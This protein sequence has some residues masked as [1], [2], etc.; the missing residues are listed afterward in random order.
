M[1]LTSIVSLLFPKRIK[2]RKQMFL[3][4]QLVFV[5]V[6]GIISTGCGNVST[7]DPSST[8]KAALVKI[9]EATIHQAE[10]TITDTLIKSYIRVLAAD[11]LLGR[12]PFTLGEDRT[13]HYLTKQFKEIGWDPGNKGSYLQAVPMVQINSTPVKELN[14]LTK[15]TSFT[16]AYKKDYVASSEREQESIELKNCPIVFAGFGIVAPEYGWNDYKNLDVKGKVVL[17][18]VNDPGFEGKDPRFFKGDTMTYY[19]RWTYKY[20]EAARQGAAGVLIIHQT[21]PASYGWS[22]VNNSFTGDKL[23]LQA[24]DKHASRCKM[25]GW[26]S[27]EA[28]NHLFKSSGLSINVA[29]ATVNARKREFRAIPL[30]LNLTLNLH[31]KLKYSTSYNL[32]AM[33]KGADQKAQNIIYTAHWDHL[34]IGPSINGDSIY[35]GAI[36]NGSGVAALLSIGKAFQALKTKLPRSVILLFVTAEEQGLLG[37]EFYA[38]HPIFPLNQTIANINL[39][40]LG[41]YGTTKD[42]S[43]V[44]LGQ[45]ELDDYVQKEA[46]SEGRHVVG[47]PNPG[48]GSYF[49]SDH[50][51]FAKVGI[52]ALDLG[53]GTESIAKGAAW[54]KKMQED[55][56]DHHYHQPSDEYSP[57]MDASGMTQNARLFF[58][59]GYQ[60]SVTNMIPNWKSGSEFKE[61]REKSKP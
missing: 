26:I 15:S 33:M 54:G 49:R 53:E 36:D 52:P 14:I 18:L 44:G 39:D 2:A 34:G 58:K 6:G 47:D 19:G 32:I 37:S 5:V 41:M 9:S 28:S 57:S 46:I 16:L 8:S 3:S 24:Y 40:A 7:D 10:N 43:L 45:S 27:E 21:K 11:S 4:F 29:E 31:N 25:E 50:F 51:N 55:Y 12:K 30:G 23:L 13:L 1:M 60:L 48:A 20:E 56:N 35:N 42:V 38:T 22:V 61:I 59:V 17:V